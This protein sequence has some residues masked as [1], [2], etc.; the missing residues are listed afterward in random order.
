MN[1]RWLD[2]TERVAVSVE[3]ILRAQDGSGAF[4]AS[5]DFPQYRYCWLRDGSFT[6]YALDR[7]GEAGA[8]RRFHEWVAAAVARVQELIYRAI[9]RADAGS[10]VDA[11]AMPPA[12]FSLD[13]RAVADEWPNFQMDGYGTWLWSLHHH[14]L[15]TGGERLPRN[16]LKAAAHAARYLVAFGTAPC[17]DVWEEDGGSVHTA[18]LACVYG[19]LR[20]AAEL[21][22]EPAFALRATEVREAVLRQGSNDGVY[23]K[24]DHSADV[25][26]ALLWLSQPFQL[27][28]PGDQVLAETLRRISTEL[29]LRGGTRRYPADSYYG[30]GAWPVLTAS[31]GWHYA[32][33]GDLAAAGGCLDWISARFDD[34]GRLGEQFG[35][36]ARD[37]AHYREWVE[38]WGPPAADLVW[39]HAMY[40]IL[41]SEV[42]QPSRMSTNTSGTPEPEGAATRNQ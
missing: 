7:A 19:G 4:V 14:V 17:F 40:V 31:L 42:S 38:R 2:G 33:A 25:D 18:T 34:E 39:S 10:P 8:A 36:D 13:G 26:A 37:P 20:A 27:V 15:A 41:A 28:P 5:G 12:R 9:R 32:A 16:V 6:A 23:R 22:D 3:R 29:D 21:L 24:S 11:S 30:G 1:E 35:G